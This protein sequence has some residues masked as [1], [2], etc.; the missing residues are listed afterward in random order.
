MEGGGPATPLKNQPIVNEWKSGD[1]ILHISLRLNGTTRR[2]SCWLRF[3]PKTAGQFLRG[4]KHLISC[5]RRGGRLVIGARE[6]SSSCRITCMS[7][8]ALRSG[9]EGIGAM[10]R[11]L[12]SNGVARLGLARRAADLAAKFLG[13]TG[14]VGRALRRQVGVCAAKPRSR[15]PSRQCRRLAVP[16]RDRGPAMVSNGGRR[17]RDAVETSANRNAINL[18]IDSDLRPPTSSFS[19]FPNLLLPCLLPSLF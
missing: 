17:S 19:A 1:G 9:L 11:F 2:S 12:E 14:A 10:G 4:R 7:F 8:A 3:A 13:S 6:D 5:A 15:R 16:R 18:A